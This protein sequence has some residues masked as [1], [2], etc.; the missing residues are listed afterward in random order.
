M[1]V[2]DSSGGAWLRSASGWFETENA[3]K[4]KTRAR[5]LGKD[6]EYAK[7]GIDGS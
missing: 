2:G 6:P 1:G 7:V 5:N 4:K 3:E